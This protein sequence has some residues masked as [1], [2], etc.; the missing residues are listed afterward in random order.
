MKYLL[1]LFTLICSSCFGVTDDDL[2]AIETICYEAQ[3]EPYEGQVAVASVIR[4][5][6]EKRNKTAEQVVKRKRHFS[7]WNKGVKRPAITPETF[8]RASRAWEESK[9]NRLE[10]NLY[11]N[12]SL[13]SP[14]WDW[15]KVVEVAV[16]SE[17]RFLWE[18]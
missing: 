18:G 11:Y 15:S 14:K 3:T 2:I 10:A 4:N 9:E 16:I 17:H 5:R 7:C 12:P 13:C 8:Q 1:I 6:M